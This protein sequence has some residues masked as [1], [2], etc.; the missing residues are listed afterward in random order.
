MSK[1]KEGLRGNYK[2]SGTNQVQKSS[3]TT[4]E[5]YEKKY[6]ARGLDFCSRKG[7]VMGKKPFCRGG[8]VTTACGDGRT[9]GRRTKQMFPKGRKKVGSRFANGVVCGAKKGPSAHHAESRR[10]KGDHS[11]SQRVH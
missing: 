8:G 7:D 11:L 6:G 3:S 1:K 10:K 5:D 4:K 9:K 2:R